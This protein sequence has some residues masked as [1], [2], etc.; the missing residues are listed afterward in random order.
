[1]IHRKKTQ[2]WLL[3]YE[4]ESVT[5]KNAPRLMCIPEKCMQ[6]IYPDSE[7]ES[8]WFLFVNECMCNSVLENDFRHFSIC[9]YNLVNDA[10]NKPFDYRLIDVPNYHF[11]I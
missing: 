2:N 5:Y 10:R 4:Y 1:M 9:N 7:L 3:E 8:G 11:E 6:I